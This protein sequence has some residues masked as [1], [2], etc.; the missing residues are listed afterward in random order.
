MKKHKSRAGAS[1]KTVLVGYN[2][3]QYPFYALKSSLASEFHYF[4]SQAN[5]HVFLI[6]SHLFPTAHFNLYVEYCS[7]GDFDCTVQ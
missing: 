6:Y 5:Q 3:T 7:D 4:F 2:L 1:P